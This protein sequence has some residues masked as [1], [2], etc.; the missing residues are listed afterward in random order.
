MAR[1]NVAIV[2]AGWWGT[3]A[4]IPAL[5]DH[6]DAAVVAVQSR[7]LDKARKIAADFGVPHACTTVDEVLAID[8]LDAV[9]VSSTPNVHY[10]HAKAALARGKHVLIEKPMTITVAESEELV[11]LA[12]RNGLQFLV[13]C[14]WHFTPHSIEARRL[15]QSGKLGQIKMIGVMMTNFTEGLYQGLTWDEVFGKNPTR[16]NAAQP[17]RA[18]GL[19]SYSD[20]AVAGGGQIYCQVSHTGAYIGFLT[21]SDPAEV[22]ARFDNGHAQ[23]DVYDA[24]NIKLKDGTLVSMASHGAPM[25]SDRQNEVRV[26]GTKGQILLELWKGKMEF[27]DDAFHVTRYPDIAE[28]NIYPM[29]E[30]ARNLVDSITGAAP[31][32]SPATLGL[33]AMRI[34]EAAVQS[35]RTGANVIVG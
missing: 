16:Q 30:P 25:P 11:D 24:L 18:P 14:P 3:A 33:Y 12:Q 32:G 13:S 17:Y 34:I 28:E 20:P 23:V 10:A 7:S 27:H 26:Y 1:V 31:N 2:G 15:I 19:A 21:G 35:A 4:H 29:F 6:P 5:K 9:V 22:F 8:G